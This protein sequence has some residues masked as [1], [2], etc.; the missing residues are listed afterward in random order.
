MD[1]SPKNINHPENKALLSLIKG[2]KNQYLDGLMHHIAAEETQKIDCTICGKCCQKLQP[3]FATEDINRIDENETPQA[4]WVRKC[5]LWDEQNQ[6]HYL[7]KSP[8]LFLKGTRCDIYKSRPSACSTYPG[9][10]LPH[11]KY[12]IKYIMSQYSV[13]PIVY[14]SIERLKI[15]LNL[16]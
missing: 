10:H 15:A 11:F 9:L 16:C 3:P 5:L 1:Y 2:S 7:K 13:C 6:M 14:N 8:C 12:R 4:E